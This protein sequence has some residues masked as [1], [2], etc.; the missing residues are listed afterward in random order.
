MASSTVTAIRPQSTVDLDRVGSAAAAISALSQLRSR[1][2]E[3]KHDDGSE[4]FEW[5][6]E[7]FAGAI[8]TAIE[9]LAESI[10]RAAW[11]ARP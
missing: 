9:A 8:T 7:Y 3:A 1:L 6:G 4:H 2:E 5:F 11:A 10:D